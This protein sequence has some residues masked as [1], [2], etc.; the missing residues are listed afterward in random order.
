MFPAIL[1]PSIV[2]SALVFPPPDIKIPP[3][4]ESAQFAKILPFLS[5]NFDAV[6]VLLSF[7]YTPPPLVAALFIA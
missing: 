4:L 6:T 7:I 2:T 1:P 3:P 5:I